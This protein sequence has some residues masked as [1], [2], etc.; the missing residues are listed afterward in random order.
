MEWIDRLILF[1]QAYK[2]GWL[3]DILNAQKAPKAADEPYSRK[4]YP[5]ETR[6]V[7]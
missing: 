4:V 5:Q 1:A 6:V 3:D 2:N 7:C